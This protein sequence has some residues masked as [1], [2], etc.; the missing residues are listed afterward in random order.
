MPRMLFPSGSVP[1]RP[2]PFLSILDPNTKYPTV[3][4][5]DYNNVNVENTIQA[6]FRGWMRRGRGCI[7]VVRSRTPLRTFRYVQLCPYMS[8]P[9]WLIVVGCMGNFESDHPGF[10]DC[11]WFDVLIVSCLSSRRR[12]SGADQLFNDSDPKPPRRGDHPRQGAVAPFRKHVHSLS[13]PWPFP[14]SIP[15]LIYPG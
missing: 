9:R 4:F 13:S 3:N 8:K 11:G 14:W 1:S 2:V 12:L 10:Q 15:M 7:W 5:L 6:S